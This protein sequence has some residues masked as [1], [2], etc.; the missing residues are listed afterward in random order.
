MKKNKKQEKLTDSQISQAAGGST[1]ADVDFDYVFTGWEQKS[2]EE[3]G[4][5]PLKGYK[6]GHIPVS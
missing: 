1:T 5:V 3:N 2:L 4:K 6:K